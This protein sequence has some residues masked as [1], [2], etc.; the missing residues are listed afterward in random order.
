M[1]ARQCHEAPRIQAISW[2]LR[3]Q[4]P[5]CWDTGMCHLARRIDPLKISGR[6]GSS[7]EMDPDQ[8]P[9]DRTTGPGTK[10]SDFKAALRSYRKDQFKHRPI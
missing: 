3:P 4:L 5:E 10:H 7:K 6:K 2:E 1:K 9:P 8:I